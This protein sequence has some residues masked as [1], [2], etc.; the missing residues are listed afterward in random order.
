MEFKGKRKFVLRHWRGRGQIIPDIK[1]KKY[2]DYPKHRGKP[3][4]YLDDCLVKE[5]TEEEFKK[6]VLTLWGQDAL[7]RLI[8]KYKLK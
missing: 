4:Y 3:P 5:I 6:E 2:Y 8:K 7:N 1:R